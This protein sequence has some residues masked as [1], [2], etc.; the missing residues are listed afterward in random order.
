MQRRAHYSTDE[1]A[2]FTLADQFSDDLI[3]GT[4]PTPDKIDAARNLLGRLSYDCERLR[5]QLDR[6]LSGLGERNAKKRAAL[7]AIIESEKHG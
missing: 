4:F 6:A 2:A 3:D 5:Y 1:L 7:R